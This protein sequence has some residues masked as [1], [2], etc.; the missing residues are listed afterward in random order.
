MHVIKETVNDDK[1]TLEFDKSPIMS[2]YLVAAAVGRFEFIE[3][4]SKRVS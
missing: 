1:K 3:K 4:Q 2:M